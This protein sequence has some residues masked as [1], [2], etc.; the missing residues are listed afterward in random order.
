MDLN[1]PTPTKKKK[2][3]LLFWFYINFSIYTNLDYNNQKKIIAQC[4]LNILKSTGVIG[5]FR[6]K[7]IKDKTKKL[8]EVTG[9]FITYSQ[10]SS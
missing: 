6:I 7:N 10:F 5:Y 4:V 9:V 2:R 1:S 3:V 8:Y